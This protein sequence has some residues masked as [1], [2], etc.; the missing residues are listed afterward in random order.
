MLWV[1]FWYDW[2]QH[3]CR[4]PNKTY[5][6]YALVCTRCKPIN[7]LLLLR[8]FLFDISLLRLGVYFVTWYHIDISL[9]VSMDYMD[10]IE[11]I[12]LILYGLNYMASIIIEL[13]IYSFFWKIQTQRSRSSVNSSGIIH[14]GVTLT[15]HARKLPFSHCFNC[16]N[17][18]FLF[19]PMSI[20]N[21]LCRVFSIIP[22]IVGIFSG[23]HRSDSTEVHSTQHDALND[24]KQ[25]ALKA[26]DY[27]DVRTIQTK[28]ST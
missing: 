20:F 11:Q 3:W 18:P 16:I 26:D 4:R 6:L 5:I 27:S 22:H 9:Y 1:C 14:S 10:I 21:C 25:N 15:L 8:R 12:T 17:I 2:I 13:V 23:Q 7:R 28:G 19:K 24:M